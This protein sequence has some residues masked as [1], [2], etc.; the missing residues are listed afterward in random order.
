MTL[1]EFD[2]LLAGYGS[3]RTRWPLEQRAGAGRLLAHDRNALRLLAEAEALD[4]LLDSAPLPTPDLD[5]L[6]CRVVA[7]VHGMPRIAASTPAV[8]QPASVPRTSP[9]GYRPFAMDS[10]GI[11]ALVTAASLVLGILIGLSGLPQSVLR[12]VQ[13]LT[14]L[15]IASTAAAH[16]A[17]F[18]T[19]DEDLL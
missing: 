11:G 7:A 6:A 18:D 8:V 15:P 2:E 16:T 10:I 5:A 17:T 3:E 9:G 4:R 19:L 14:G 13:L 1:E 12:P